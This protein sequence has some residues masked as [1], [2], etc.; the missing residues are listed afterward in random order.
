MTDR[1]T[2]D[3]HESDARVL[4][5]VGEQLRRLRSER[6]LTLAA[7]AE[8]TGISTSTLSRLENGQRRPTLELLLAIARVHRVALDDLIGL[9]DEV[10]P[11]IRL[12]AR[13]VHGRTV[14]P[15][16]RTGGVQAWKITLPP[17]RERP[18]LRRHEGSE[19]LYV[20][21]GEMRLILGGQDLVLHQGEAAEFDT[22]RPH[23][24][25]SAGRSRAEIL[26]LFNRAGAQVHVQSTD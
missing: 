17:R 11:R 7:L 24:F 3:Q 2:T 9:P 18:E 21:S 12:Q 4:D 14:V 1:Q 20:L 19:W 15:L 8:S 22:Q 25:G 5:G 23:W 6:G 13:R 16:S 26:S 10:D